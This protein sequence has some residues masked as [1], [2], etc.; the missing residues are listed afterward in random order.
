MNNLTLIR[1]ALGN[2]DRTGRECGCHADQY[3][4]LLPLMK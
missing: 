1:R 3:A 4:A 2:L